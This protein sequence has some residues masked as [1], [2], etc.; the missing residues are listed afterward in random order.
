MKISI[1][2]EKT[3]NKTLEYEEGFWTG[4]KRLVYDGVQ[5]TKIKRNLF[6]WRSDEACETFEIK[7]NQLFGV[8]VKA[9]GEEIEVARKLTWQ[10]IL[11]SVIVFI[12]CML[13]GAIGGAI[14]GALGFTNLTIIRNVKNIWLKILISIEFAAVGL[15][16][17]YLIACLL[18]KAFTFMGI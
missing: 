18:F 11:L 4:K 15:L 8:V 3:K 2:N 5:L 13:F 6:E 14:G 10:E 12:P 9:F 7:G 1:N 16:L 17:S